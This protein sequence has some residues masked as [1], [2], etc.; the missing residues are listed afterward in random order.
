M[1]GLLV[2]GCA[3]ARRGHVTT[4]LI[5]CALAAEV[6]VPAL[7]GAL[8]I[9]W[10]WSGDGEKPWR[11][12]LPR[13]LTASLITVAFIAVIGFVSGLGWGW[14]NGLTASGSVVSW[15]DPVTAVGLSLSHVSGALSLGAHSSAYVHSS[16]ALGLAVA[17]LISIGLLV[18]SDR[19]GVMQALGWSLL[20]FVVLGPV[21][22]P[23]YETWGFVF[24][25]VIAEAWTLRLLLALSAIA[26]FADL[27]SIRFY[28]AA[29]P[30]LAVACWTLLVGGIVIYGLVRLWP[31]LRVSPPSPIGQHK[32][33][34]VI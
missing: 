4:G 34:V 17:A 16:R 15:V 26:C 22:W 20:V 10:W 13:I 24:L 1:L 6:K 23:W 11:Q 25:A 33:E 18:R 12:R 7:I 28:E 8:F 2:A 19:M 31:S 21:I 9:G 5:L 30:I 3:A 32:R 14:L 29:D 27:P